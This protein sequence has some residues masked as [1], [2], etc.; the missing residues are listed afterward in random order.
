MIAALVLATASAIT[1]AD[2]PPFVVKSNEERIQIANRDLEFSIR[3][4]GYV[5][6]VMGGSFVDRAT[7]SRDLGFGLDIVDWIM[8]PG[9]DEAYR[10][11]LPGDFSLHD[12]QQPGPRQ[13]LAPDLKAR[14][15]ARRPV[16]LPPSRDLRQG[17]PGGHSRISPIRL[18]AAR[19]GG[20][21]S[22]G[23]DDRLP[24]RQALLPPSDRVTGRQRRRGHR[25]SGSTC[26]VI[27]NIRQ[28]DTFSEVYPQLSRQRSPPREFLAD[29]APGREVPL[30][31]PGTTPSLA[32]SS[33]PTTSE[34]RKPAKPAPG[35]PG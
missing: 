10:D 17:L 19:Q 1:W 34:T 31:R 35:S 25:S 6:G 14:R 5:S 28:G 15:S 30:A 27:S 7:G 29:F 16:E 2:E 20:R 33:A 18:A 26:P 13:A 21:L 12:V 23:A 9:S 32:G 4:S 24:G 22:M 11:Q 3:R 8:E